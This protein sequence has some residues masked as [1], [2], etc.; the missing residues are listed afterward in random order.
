V[1]EIGESEKSETLDSAPARDKGNKDQ[2]QQYNDNK[3]RST[4]STVSE[5][6]M[7]LL[8]QPKSN[9]LITSFDPNRYRV[10]K[11]HRSSVLLQRG[12]EPA[13]MRNVS[14]TRSLGRLKMPVSNSLRQPPTK[15]TRSQD[16]Q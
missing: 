13:I 12:N 16:N 7:M 11:R 10:V 14:L 2:M 1:P 9:T 5:M 8:K 15:N 3:N 6:D 4:P